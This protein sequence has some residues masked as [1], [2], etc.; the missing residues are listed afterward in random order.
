MNKHDKFAID[1]NL[2]HSSINGYD[3]P[4]KAFL[5]HNDSTSVY[6]ISANW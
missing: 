4:T 6:L 2:D 3:G 5:L 1:K